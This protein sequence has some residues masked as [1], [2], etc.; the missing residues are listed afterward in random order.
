MYNAHFVMII[1]VEF[2]D[3]GNFCRVENRHDTTTNLIET[4]HN[5]A[6]K[7][8]IT[9]TVVFMIFYENICTCKF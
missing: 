8:A 3:G 5:L 9:T 7:F 6:Y 2:N 4:N 1:C